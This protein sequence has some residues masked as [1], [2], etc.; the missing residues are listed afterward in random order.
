MGKP[1]RLRG[2][3]RLG[4]LGVI[5]LA[6]VSACGS[7]GSVSSVATTKVPVVVI[8][9]ENHTY[10]S[11]IGNA[12]APFINK[13]LIAGGTVDTNYVAQVGSL[14]DYMMIVSGARTPVAFAPNLFTA[15]GTTTS[16]REFMES[17]PSACYPAATSGLVHGT[18]DG[19]YT[20][21]HNP[22]MQFTTVVNTTLCQ[23]IVPLTTSTLHPAALPAFSLIVPN[24]CNDMEDKP[25]NNQCPMW[26]GTTNTAPNTVKMGDNWLASIV[27]KLAPYATVIV[28]WDEGAPTN[29][30]IMT[31]AY[32]VG[33]S[34]G[35]DATAYTH[36]SLE[37]SL[38]SYYGLGA[39]PG[40]GATATP[41]ALP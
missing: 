33:V 15:L 23:N 21:Y 3:L 31:L 12:N 30:Q 20:N 13:T 27:P 17:M 5:A 7:A 34:P 39:A 29:E 38:Y 37:A 2:A 40:N 19:L 28:T 9:L 36:A 22:A 18:T 35:K 4:A 26:D 8:V 32:G 11:L 6:L 1:A 10:K 25:T 41:L 16:W 24:Q 14:P